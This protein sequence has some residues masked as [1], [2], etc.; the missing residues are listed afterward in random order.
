MKER[1]RWTGIGTEGQGKR[2]K[3]R[4]KRIQGKGKMDRDR[5]KRVRETE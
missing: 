3:E 4:E 5:K 1:E 2:G